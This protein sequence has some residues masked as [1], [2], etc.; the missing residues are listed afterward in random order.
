LEVFN[1]TL[2]L[3]RAL[4][5]PPR[6]KLRPPPSSLPS[7]PLAGSSINRPGGLTKATFFLFFIIVALLILLFNTFSCSSLC[8]DVDT[9]LIVTTMKDDDRFAVRWNSLLVAIIICG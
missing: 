4:S 2:C 3:I 7:L 1:K 5:V 9:L 8:I 6:G